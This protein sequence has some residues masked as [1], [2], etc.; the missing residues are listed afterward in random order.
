MADNLIYNLCR[1]YKR[2]IHSSVAGTY[3]V[4]YSMS[5]R[6]SAA[7]VNWRFQIA[8]NTGAAVPNSAS[9]VQVGNAGA[10]G[11][12][13]VSVTVLITT[14][15]SSTYK[16]QWFRAN[17]GTVTLNNNL[18][19]GS[20]RVDWVQIG[21][22]P[23]PMSLAGEYGEQGFVQGSQQIIGNGVTADLNGG[24]FVIPTAGVWVL[25]YDAE[26]F[27][28]SSVFAVFITDSNNAEIANS[29]CA[30]QNNNTSQVGLTASAGGIVVTTSGP[31]TYKMRATGV[32]IQGYSLARAQALLSI[33]CTGERSA[34]SLRRP[35]A[36]ST[37]GSSPTQ[38]PQALT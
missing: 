29:R 35:E 30:L 31:T 33:V 2:I 11:S 37:T 38:T 19:E 24:T 15:G 7:N 16:M 9:G 3:A 10:L 27:L 32:Q 25:G 21:G 8:D 13:S 26:V 18:T 17:G 6:G 14:T 36:Q 22:T 12:A 5:A 20:S 1:H 34:V 23:V 28:T 4:T